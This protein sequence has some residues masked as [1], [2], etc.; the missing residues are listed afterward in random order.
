MKPPALTEMPNIWDFDGGFRDIYVLT[1]T[2]QDWQ[3]F[4]TFATS[5]PHS[6]AVDG[7]IAAMP[8]VAEI[9]RANDH[10]HLLSIKV[11]DVV[12][13][14]HFFEEDRIEVD[15][16]PREVRG[17]IEHDGV[18]VFV[19]GLARSV[20]KSVILTPENETGNPILSYEPAS[21]TWLC[22]ADWSPTW[23]PA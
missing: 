17:S 21:D 19:A 8:D 3:R 12:L 5:Y 15:I 23:P 22:K 16:D 1:T 7:E 4:L 9:F 10:A 13:N 11:G 2:I 14:C 18:L 6:Y 20:A